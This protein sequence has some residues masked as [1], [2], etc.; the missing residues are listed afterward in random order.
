MTAID[1][2]LE[3]ALDAALEM[4]FPASDPIAVFMD[5]SG[6]GEI[7]ADR[8]QRKVSIDASATV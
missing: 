6:S 1:N 5:E 7:I 2:P 4:T 3:E 8:S